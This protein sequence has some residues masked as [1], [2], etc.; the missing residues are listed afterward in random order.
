MSFINVFIRAISSHA[1]RCFDGF[2]SA[3]DLWE[4]VF[5]YLVFVASY[6]YGSLMNFASHTLLKYTGKSR[7]NEAGFEMIS[8]LRN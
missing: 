2:L 7:F 1:H 3:F 6:D 5:I 8:L 4:S